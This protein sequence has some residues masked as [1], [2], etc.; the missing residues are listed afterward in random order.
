MVL[1]FLW[2]G[3]RS[4]EE[5]GG[6]V[7]IFWGVG[8]VW[9]RSEEWW[10]IKNKTKGD[11]KKKLKYNSLLLSQRQNGEV[12]EDFRWTLSEWEGIS[13]NGRLFRDMLEGRRALEEWEEGLMA[14]YLYFFQ[15]QDLDCVPDSLKQ[16]W[17]C[18]NFPTIVMTCNDFDNGGKIPTD[19]VLLQWIWDTIQILCLR[20]V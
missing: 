11:K 13:Q 5:V 8:F 9:G 16:N 4:N 19:P 1:I 12:G 20:K 6:D 18:G 3:D 7:K 10:K 17:I 14:G 2:H 15:V